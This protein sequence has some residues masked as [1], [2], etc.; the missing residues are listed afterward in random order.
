MSGNVIIHGRSDFIL[1]A[2]IFLIYHQFA[3]AAAMS[4]ANVI[5]IPATITG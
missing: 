2:I 3:N 4:F 5:T 1:E